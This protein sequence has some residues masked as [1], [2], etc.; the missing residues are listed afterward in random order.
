MRVGIAL[1]SILR[2]VFLLVLFVFAAPNLKA[3][4]PLLVQHVSFSSTTLTYAKLAQ[5]IKQQSDINIAFDAKSIRSKDKLQLPKASMSVKELSAF[6]HKSYGISSQ[7]IGR[8][9]ILKPSLQAQKV[10]NKKSGKKRSL[11]RK[12]VSSKSSISKTDTKPKL[13]KVQQNFPKSALVVVTVEK[14]RELD[15]VYSF[16]DT[17]SISDSLLGSIS[18]LSGMSASAYP[19]DSNRR[20]VDPD[21]INFSPPFWET[22]HLGVQFSA[23]D[24][25]IAN[26]ALVLG[27]KNFSFIAKYAIKGAA[28]HFRYGL[29][30]QLPLNDKFRIAAWAEFGNLSL[31]RNLNWRYSYTVPDSTLPGGQAIVNVDTGLSYSI[32]TNLLKVGIDGNYA[33]FKNLDVFAGIQLN[34]ESTVVYF[35]GV[36][37]APNAFLPSTAP[38]RK[39]DY[40]FLQLRPTLNS[41]FSFDSSKNSQLTIGL[42]IGLRLY[43]LK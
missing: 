4:K 2:I 16:S 22:I 23:D 10:G 18:A 36:E 6:L 9:I 35:G 11:L 43:F 38:F 25:F 15:T 8:T 30:Y 14:L 28:S 33:I 32:R 21:I 41:D 13:E 26:P 17:V 3:Q 7:F 1:P 24:Y 42:Q 20:L 19:I 5:E 37:Q 31:N 29:Q 12:T 27:Y 39:E 40:L 34:R